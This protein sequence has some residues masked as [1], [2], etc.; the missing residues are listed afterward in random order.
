MNQHSVLPE[1]SQDEINAVRSKFFCF[2]QT[3]GGVL[4]S[5][6]CIMSTRLLSM[7]AT[8]FFITK[9]TYWVRNFDC[10]KLS[11]GLALPLN[12]SLL[13]I[14][15]PKT[16]VSSLRQPCVPNSP[17][18]WCQI[19][20]A[21]DLLWTFIGCPSSFKRLMTSIS[22]KIQLETDCYAV[23]NT[24]SEIHRSL[25]YRLLW[26]SSSFAV[27][28][29]FLF[30]SDELNAQREFTKFSIASDCGGLVVEPELNIRRQSAQ[31][32]SFTTGIIWRRSACT[33]MCSAPKEEKLRLLEI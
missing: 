18:M 8:T 30:N 2:C 15:H 10:T 19:E 32:S 16:S 33:K 28:V 20:I 25:L 5:A 23:G 22:N 12:H 6:S 4:W 14:L 3:R 7:T 31:Q 9:N 11:W 17:L 26:L 29:T 21:T 27:Y 24:A 13:P 1:I